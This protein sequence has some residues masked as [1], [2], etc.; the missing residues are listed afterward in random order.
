MS[1]QYLG[2]IHVHCS[3]STLIGAIAASGLFFKF[4]MLATR[5]RYMQS[6]VY[7]HRKKFEDAI[8]GDL[9]AERSDQHDQ[10]ITS[11]NADY[12]MHEQLL[13]AD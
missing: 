13:H 12:E 4:F 9:V 10:P 11:G 6:F 1:K 5:V 7:P 3:R 8:F 2:C